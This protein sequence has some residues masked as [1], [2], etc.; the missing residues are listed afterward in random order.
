MS[1]TDRPVEIRTDAAP[2]P[3]GPYSQAI[4]SGDLVFASGQIPLD[5]KTGELV[6]G[7]IE[8][9]ARQVL[10]NLRAVLEAAGSGLDRVLRATVYLTDLSLF[11]R[12]N[13]VYAEA[14]S[15]DPAPARVTIG[16]ASLPLGANVEID[17]IA[18][19]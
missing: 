18:R 19:R 3:V 16:V 17:A 9:E 12:V 10:A 6:R 13:A 8:D 14:F 5:P 7:E 2:A 4:A 1:D 11:P 15:A